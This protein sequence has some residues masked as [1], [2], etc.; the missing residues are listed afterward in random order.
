MYGASSWPADVGIGSWADTLVLICS[1]QR[2]NNTVA[3]GS[4]I[5]KSAGGVNTQRIAITKTG[6][7]V[8]Y[9]S[10]VPFPTIN[11]ANELQIITI[12]DKNV[13]YAKAHTNGLITV[14]YP[15]F[16][17]ADV[18]TCLSYLSGRPLGAISETRT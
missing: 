5:A 14:R 8:T 1:D 12:G 11:Y 10:S 17:D 18:I 3:A 7:R 15:N 16:P 2:A 13:E 9:T 6:F 4:R